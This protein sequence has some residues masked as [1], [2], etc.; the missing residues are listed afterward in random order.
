MKQAEISA[1]ADHMDYKAAKL[2]EQADAARR[3]AQDM[4]RLAAYAPE[5]PAKTQANI[6]A[7]WQGEHACPDAGCPLSKLAVSIA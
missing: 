7:H 3:L 2:Q 4:R 1:A 6:L 5:L